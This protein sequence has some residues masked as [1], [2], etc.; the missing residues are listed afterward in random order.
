MRQG[1][2]AVLLIPVFLVAG[3]SQSKPVQAPAKRQS[4]NTASTSKSIQPSYLA[5]PLDLGLANLGSNFKGHDITAI[6]RAIKK[7]SALPAKSEFEST[8]AFDTK[9]AAFVDRQLYGTLKPSDYLGFVADDTPTEFKYDADSQ[10]LTVT[11]TDSPERF[12]LEND[13][14]PTLDSVLV[15]RIVLS[16]DRYIGGNA[17]GAKVVVTR[18]NSQEYGVAFNQNNWLF[19]SSENYPP[20]FSYQFA[21]GPEEAR[22]TKANAKLLL[23][24]RL[25]DPWLRRSA[26]G[27]NPTINSPTETN[28]EENYLEVSLEQLW[29]FNQKTGQI[30]RKMSESSAASDKDQQ[31]TLKLTQTPLILEVAA[32]STSTG[33]TFLFNIKIDDG[34]ERL[35][36]I[37]GQTKTFTARRK[38]MLEQMSVQDLSDLRLKLNGKPYSPN[39]TKDSTRIGTYAVV[40][41][42]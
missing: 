36:T 11:L 34:P 10:I 38:I 22:A 37:D 23:V 28:V 17:F 1:S 16:R 15:R 5:A 42:P 19:P 24:C 33:E 41:V 26:H 40:T 7:S 27:D 12:M 14:Y 8:A 39:W 35:D 4:N 6:F 18:T 31:F 20:T 3:H 32:D 30:I 2:F 25:S 13:D 21:I 29:V 9:R